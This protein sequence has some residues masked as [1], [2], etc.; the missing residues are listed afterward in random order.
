MGSPVKDFFVIHYCLQLVMFVRFPTFHSY[1]V[2]MQYETNIMYVCMYVCINMTSHL[3]TRD[4]HHLYI[5]RDIWIAFVNFEV[6]NDSVRKC[7]LSTA[8]RVG[9]TEKKKLE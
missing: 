1:Y 9:A 8:L 4:R 5:I 3:L 7:D 6:H 2:S